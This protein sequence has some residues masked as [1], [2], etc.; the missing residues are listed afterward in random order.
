MKRSEIIRLS[1]RT[2]DRK[3]M[4]ARRDYVVGI[5]T[6][7][8]FTD[9]ALLDYHSREVISA[10]K[11]LTTREDLSIG[12]VRAL[13]ELEIQNPAWVRLVGISSTLAT[14]SIA[15]GRAREVALLLIGYDPDLMAR[16]GLASKL[17][18]DRV[19]HFRGGH[20]SQGAEREPL[21][22]AGIREWVAENAGKVDALAVSSY[23][24]PLN[25]SHEEAAFAAIQSVSRL[26]VV[27][28]HQ[29]STK[30]DSIRR[31]T[32]ACLNASLVAIM[33]EFIQAVQQALD[34]QGIRAPL[35][36]VKGDGSLMPHT[37]A[38]QKPVE[39][40]LS[41]PAASAIGGRFLSGHDSAVVI[42]VGGTTTDI[43]FI[44][45]GQMAV[46]DQ[47]AR[48]GPVETAVKAVRIRTACLG[49]D[50]CI[51]LGKGRTIQ[52]GPERVVPLCRLASHHARVRDD[53]RRLREKRP[54]EW[55]TTDLEYW[56]AY[57]PGAA[58]PSGAGET[59]AKLMALLKDGPLSLTEILKRLAV[60][61]PVQLGADAL[62]EKGIVERA[63][64]TPTDLLHAGGQIDLW[65]GEAARIAVKRLCELHQRKPEAFI[66]TALTQMV[67][68]MVA[69]VFIF[70]ARQNVPRD[71]PE[72]LADGWGRWLFNEALTDRNRFLSVSL[73]SRFPVIGIGGPAGYFVRRVAEALNAPFV[74]PPSAAIANAV[75]A[76]AGTVSYDQEALLFM[77]E[78]D[79]GTRFVVQIDGQAPSFLEE[80][81][82]AI[83][84]A[85]AAV[86][87]MALA[88]ALQAGAISPQV[89]VSQAID[90]SVRRILARAVGNPELSNT[91]SAV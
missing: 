6:G 58:L 74:L 57:K 47:G 20:N 43:A 48:V 38:T 54:L 8:T 16:Y 24:S 89:I 42:D 66:E 5:D 10:R 64:L 78:T 68:E 67:H 65:D 28:G 30:I 1:S 33:Q 55:L 75:G 52:I 84:Q 12:I 36:I 22:V 13:G 51:T 73:A 91:H 85:E 39:T 37:V 88:G 31:A 90:G 34:T 82:T 80:E 53:I 63:T 7:G 11:T 18:T 29:L 62:L 76:V 14:N 17:P 23:F 86:R 77:K 44:E 41:G 87:E 40:V 50:S 26:P 35:M 21:D 27:L 59:A 81:D 46:S 9:G 70:L 2:D 19:V 3:P 69:E 25:P 45:N 79:L 61:H 72:T 49:C 32:T 83:E 60:N 56:I 4:N 71:L 15:E